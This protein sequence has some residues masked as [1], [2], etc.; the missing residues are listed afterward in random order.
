ML[1]PIIVMP[2]PTVPS[3]LKRARKPASRPA[4]R[5]KTAAPQPVKVE[6][7]S[8]KSQL[9]ETQLED[10]IEAPINGG[11]EVAVATTIHDDN[12][13][14]GGFDEDQMDDFNGIN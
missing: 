5:R 3:V 12:T 8:F 11:S 9:R 1:A 2:P 14:D 13:S 10:A 4:K 7:D 6:P